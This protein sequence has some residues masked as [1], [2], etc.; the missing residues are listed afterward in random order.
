MAGY[1]DTYGALYNWNAVNT[2]DLCPTGWH[3]PS[4][5]EWTTL[6]DYLGGENQVAHKLME[7]GTEHW[8][9]PNANAT[10]ETGFTALPA[11]HRYYL[12]GGFF[13]FGSYAGWWSTTQNDATTTWYRFISTG[14]GDQVVRAGAFKGNGHSVRCLMD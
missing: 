9:S 10:N 12:G 1:G 4:D 13:E 2:G 5:T 8:P 6:T 3:I 7:S 14:Y 11:G